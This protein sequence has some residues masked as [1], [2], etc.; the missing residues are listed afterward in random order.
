M[1]R[2]KGTPVEEYENK[3][4]RFAG[5]PAYE[6]TEADK[7]ELKKGP[8]GKSTYQE[9]LESSM[10][11]LAADQ[12]FWDALGIGY[13]AGTRSLTRGVGGAEPAGEFEKEGM[14]AL[15]RKYPVATGAGEMAGQSI[16]FIPL[17]IV[18]GGSGLATRAGGRTILPAFTGLGKRMV[19][20]ALAGATEGAIV[21]EG[22]G[23]DPL[24][25]AAIGGATGLAA[26]IAVP[27]LKS[28]GLKIYQKA[29][30]KV[31]PGTLF[32]MRG[33]PT[34]QM[35]AA[36]D[37]VGLKYDDLKKATKKMISR[38]SPGADPEQVSK[39][40]LF[41]EDKIP[42]SRGE[43]TQASADLATEK[44]LVRKSD[45]YRDYKLAQ[46]NAVRAD[47]EATLQRD[48][49]GSKTGQL[50]EEALTT[51]E[52]VRGHIKKRLYKQVSKM[53]EKLGQVPIIPDNIK[54]SVLDPQE[55]RQLYDLDP[56]N[57]EALENLL[58]EYGLS[59]NEFWIEKA[60][61]KG[62]DR[63]PIEIK[64]LNLANFEQFRKALNRISSKSKDAKRAIMPIKHALDAELDIMAESVGKNKLPPELLEK[65]KMARKIHKETIEE[66]TP[67]NLVGRI[68]AEKNDGV[69]AVL[70]ASKSFDSM[71]SKA[72]PAESIQKLM[73]SLNGSG[74]RGKQAIAA[75]QSSVLLDLV[76][77]S[78]KGGPRRIKGVPV[79]NPDQFRARVNSIG[80][81]KLKAIFKNRPGILKRIQNADKRAS[82]MYADAVSPEEAHSAAGELLDYL[83]VTALAPEVP[84]GLFLIGSFKRGTEPAKLVAQA[85]KA[86]FPKAFLQ[87][88]RTFADNFPG[89]A[90]ALGIPATLTAE[91]EIQNE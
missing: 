31:P 90:R 50:I 69:T 52:M 46:S 14:A 76:E 55:M 74:K 83:S 53:S 28:L 43:M 51:R 41:K 45:T 4:P 5:T 39:L 49:T 23:G 42:I 13:G 72:L 86:K 89:I 18:S 24:K 88:K 73:V 82:L 79:F 70:E 37:E 68:V 12:S 62:G 19:G 11:E 15:K 64:T 75:L 63:P 57:T 16:P 80:E 6:L 59:E 25:G 84:K 34:K 91:E 71:M 30:G 47:L 48:L 1:P 22:T 61:L 56:T 8:S 17:S 44:K 27:I 54:R 38:Q 81:D 7:A 21:E 36:L 33:K 32:D 10:N 58:V 67:K 78:F 20:G 65:L 2:F 26:E 87:A 66:F 29:F 3:G 60:M 85:E 35:Q 40:A 9:A 77:S